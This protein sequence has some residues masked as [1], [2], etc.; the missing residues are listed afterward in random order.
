MF[1]LNREEIDMKQCPAYSEAKPVYEL[2]AVPVYELP[3]VPTKDQS[4]KNEECDGD[5]IYEKIPGES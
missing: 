5:S 2:P 1:F 4:T 3:A